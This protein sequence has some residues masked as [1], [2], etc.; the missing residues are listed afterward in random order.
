MPI[1]RWNDTAAVFAGPLFR[2]PDAGSASSAKHEFVPKEDKSPARRGPII[3]AVEF[4]DRIDIWIGETLRRQFQLVVAHGLSS[5]A[6]G[7]GFDRGDLKRKKRREEFLAALDALD[8]LTAMPGT[9]RI[10]LTNWQAK[11]IMDVLITTALR[12]TPMTHSKVRAA[13]REL[14]PILPEGMLVYFRTPPLPELS[15]VLLKTATL[16]EA[17]N[18][19]RLRALAPHRRCPVSYGS[20]VRLARWLF[21][22]SAQA[23]EVRGIAGQMRAMA[24]PYLAAEWHLHVL[25]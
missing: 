23:W 21:R 2:S 17:D 6:G 18:Y 19:E 24:R 22:L 5:F 1:R 4:E 20:V 7:A 25:S 16:D 3:V 12:A 10:R 13:L 14:L 15:E 9:C 11:R 8:A